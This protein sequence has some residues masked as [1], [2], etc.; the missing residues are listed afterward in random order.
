MMKQLVLEMINNLPDNVELEDIIEILYL[1]L[2]IEK[3]LQ[4]VKEGKT[5]S[6]ADFRK[7]IETW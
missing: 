5:M 2:K 4:D 3:G 6:L 7:E 1:K